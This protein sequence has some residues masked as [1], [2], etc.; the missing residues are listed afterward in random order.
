MIP[1]P[2][3][4]TRTFVAV[5][6]VAWALLAV[7][8]LGGRNPALLASLV[9]ASTLLVATRPP[10]APH[11]RPSVGLNRRKGSEDD[12][13]GLAL[14]LA[15]GSRHAFLVEWALELPALASSTGPTSGYQALPGHSALQAK[16]NVRI[17][18]FGTYT[19]GTSNVRVYDP[20]QL[21]ALQVLAGS[22]QEVRVYPRRIPLKGSPIRSNQVRRISGLFEI[23]Q[24]GSGFEFFGLR[25]YVPGDRP[26]DVNWKASARTEELIVNQRQRESNLEVVLLVDAQ[27]S[28]VVGRLSTNPYAQSCRA[29]LALAETHGKSRDKIRLVLYSDDLKENRHSGPLRRL[30]GATE[31]VVDTSPAGRYPLR[32]AVERIL[33]SLHRRSRVV[34]ATPLV[35]DDTVEA[36]LALLRGHDLG[37]YLIAPTPDFG[38]LTGSPTAR[39]WLEQQ[40]RRLDDIRRMGFPCS[41][42]AADASLSS[43]LAAA[44]TVSR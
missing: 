41:A 13:F 19:L 33:P 8:Y 10:N 40:A 38:D 5:T 1:R 24:P 42:W 18:L 11:L 28:A 23:S 9:V 20:L 12:D 6:V 7:G 17:P 3:Q 30:Q 15:N 44:S 35:G 14:R 27:A 34:V 29:A 32:M 43:A 36:A 22:L 39:H 25:E 26:R 4:L 37:V 31:L 2:L 21:M 16:A